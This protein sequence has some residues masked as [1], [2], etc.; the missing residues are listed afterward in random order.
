MR[1]IQFAT[2]GKPSQL[3][4]VELPDPQADERNAVIKI[5]A[6]SVN[7]SDVKNV[8]GSMEGTTLPRVPGRDFSGVVESGPPEWVG[9]DVWGAGG[10]VGF[11]RDGAHAERMLFPIAAL[12]RKPAVLTHEQ[13]SAIGVNF[14]IAWLG[15]VDYAKLDAS[16]TVAVLGASGGVG[17]AVT[18]IA[19]ARGARVIGFDRVPPPDDAP[20]AKLL[21]RFELSTGDVPGAVRAFTDGAGATLVF[22]AVGGVLF[23]TALHCAALRGRVV[24][25]SATGKRRVEFDLADFYHNETQLLGADSRKLDEVRC[26]EIFDMLRPGF[27]AGTYQ[28]PIIAQRFGLEGAVAAYELV[29]SGTA[30]RIVITP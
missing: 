23:E 18:Q 29:D 19:K 4:L 5:V 2:F 28:P 24:E 15:A 21:D 16:D 1:A 7:P 6:S 12:R 26:A 14:L 9:A 27:E 10:D 11:K 17:G 8:A 30:G 13:A 20:A 25:I 3:R 22:D